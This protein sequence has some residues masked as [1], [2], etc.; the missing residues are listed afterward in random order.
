[1]IEARTPQMG[2]HTVHVGGSQSNVAWLQDPPRQTSTDSK[3]SE[4]RHRRSRRRQS[5]FG[6]GHLS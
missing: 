1:M 6:L 2:P 4:N 3:N 5:I